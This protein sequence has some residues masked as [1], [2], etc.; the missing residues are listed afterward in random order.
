MI[1]IIQKS[2]HTH[3]H[4]NREPLFFMIINII[5]LIIRIKVELFYIKLEKEENGQ[6][7]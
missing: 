3:T 1:I 2:F 6:V 4:T 7:R 5:A